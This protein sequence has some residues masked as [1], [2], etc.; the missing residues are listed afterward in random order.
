MWCAGGE[1]PA[2]ERPLGVGVPSPPPC[3]CAS[4]E[5]RPEK[6]R[7]Q[8]MSAYGSVMGGKLSFK[9]DKS[10]KKKKRER[11]E[12]HGAGSGGEDDE[13]LLALQ[14]QGAASTDPVAG[15]GKLTTSGV[16]VMGLDTNFSKELSVGDSILVTVSDRFRN[17]QSD[18][19]RVVNMV[20]GRT[21]LNLEAP[22]S[23]DVTRPT[24]FMVM[25]K[26]PDIESLRRARAEEKK[27]QK[28]MEEES[29]TLTYKVLKAGSGTWK[30]WQTVTEKVAAG[31]T[32]EEMLQRRAKE[33]ADRF[34]K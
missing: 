1:D 20:L 31:T 30:T 24:S 15:E 14:A 16:V 7:E 25:K 17:I 23:C 22:F 8:S 13:D 12:D 2:G 33:K 6:K 29:S 27:R 10:K 21:S 34:C 11:E 9:G 28:Q 4:N 26:A 32:R 3:A 19:S 18:E 5:R